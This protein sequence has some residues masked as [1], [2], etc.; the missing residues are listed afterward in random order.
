MTVKKKAPSGIRRGL[1]LSKKR[2]S[3]PYNESIQT[4]TADGQALLTERVGLAATT[5]DHE[6]RL[7]A[8]TKKAGLATTASDPWKGILAATADE[9]TGLAATANLRL[10]ATAKKIILHTNHLLLELLL[11]Y[12]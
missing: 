7:A 10:S 1:C 11:I 6:I 4:A 3:G 9:C 2:I 5:N 8:T 12:P